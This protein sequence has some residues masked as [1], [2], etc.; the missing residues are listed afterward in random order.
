MPTN[1]DT[2]SSS[3]R[4]PYLPIEYS[5]PDA[6]YQPYYSSYY[7][8][9]YMQAYAKVENYSPASTNLPINPPS[10]NSRSNDPRLVRNLGC[11]FTGS[12]K[13]VE[14]HMMDRHLI[15]PL[16]WDNRKKSDWDADPSL[17]GKPIPIQGTNIILDS[18]DVLDAWIAERK[19]RW[20]SH[21]PCRGEKK[22]MGGSYRSRAVTHWWWAQG[23]EEKEAGDDNGPS[24]YNPTGRGGAVAEGRLGTREGWRLGSSR[25]LA[26]TGTPPLSVSIAQVQPPAPNLESISEASDNE[27]GNSA[28][29]VISS[30]I[31]QVVSEIHQTNEM[32]NPMKIRARHTRQQQPKKPA[33]NPFAS[34]P[35][36]LRNVY[37]LDISNLSQAIRFLVDN[38]FLD[39]VELK[40]G[41]AN[42]KSIEVIGAED[43]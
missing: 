11:S 2:A 37:S 19:K 14:I 17:K 6:H 38:D 1:A 15:F 30:K 32:I 35:T 40:P 21:A 36:L 28:P 20:P 10:N 43:I 27:D 39:N 23:Q 42:N 33:P 31:P 7:S 34:H 41:D 5:A 12:Q 24:D 22:R 25:S 18:P 13:T 4:T 3:S 26:D 29:E 16:G 8:Q 9:A